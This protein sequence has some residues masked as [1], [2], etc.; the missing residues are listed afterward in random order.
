MTTIDLDK[1][2]DIKINKN[3]TTPSVR[4]LLFVLVRETTMRKIVVRNYIWSPAKSSGSRIRWLTGWWPF[5]PRWAWLVPSRLNLARWRHSPR[6]QSVPRS[7][8][9]LPSKDGPCLPSPCPCLQEH[10]HTHTRTARKNSRGV[11]WN[12][13]LRVTIT[14]CRKTN[15]HTHA[16]APS[17]GDLFFFS[18]SPLLTDG[19]EIH[20]ETRNEP[21]I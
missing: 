16:R 1:A 3:K 20:K 17:S 6:P 7:D 13:S 5:R 18:L 11:C 4:L 8:H 12:Q 19:K 15:T 14:P 21:E 2:E 9:L 10:T